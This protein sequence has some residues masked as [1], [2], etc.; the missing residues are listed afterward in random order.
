MHFAGGSRLSKLN[1]WHSSVQNCSFVKFKLFQPK[2]NRQQKINL[3]LSLIHPSTFYFVYR[4]PTFLILIYY[5]F[6]SNQIYFWILQNKIF[7]YM[8][9]DY[10]LYVKISVLKVK[11]LMIHGPYTT[12]HSGIEINWNCR[13]VGA[14]QFQRS[15]F[16]TTDI[17][18]IY[19]KQRH[20]M[21][22]CLQA[23]HFN[24]V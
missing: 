9:L 23:K 6:I 8:L 24:Q 7:Y 3:I 14:R 2:L 16:L 13:P 19:R 15:L 1:I 21:G 22:S 17:S 18:R 10:K 12:F 20:D 4:L 5:I 11:Y